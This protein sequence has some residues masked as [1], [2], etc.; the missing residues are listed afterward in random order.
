MQRQTQSLKAV[1]LAPWN[2]I[3][4]IILNNLKISQAHTSY[5]RG[6]ISG[7]FLKFCN[8]SQY[9]ILTN[10]FHEMYIFIKIVYKHI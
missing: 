1:I 8:F 3:I 2:G 4:N 5:N 7:H 10:L 6:Q 9:Y